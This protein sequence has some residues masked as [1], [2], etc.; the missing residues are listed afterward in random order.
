M[1]K[2]LRLPTHQKYGLLVFIFGFLITGLISVILPLSDLIYG[3][4]QWGFAIALVIE[5]I[6]NMTGENKPLKR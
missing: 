4:I 1:K 5:V 6:A 2:Y 3:T